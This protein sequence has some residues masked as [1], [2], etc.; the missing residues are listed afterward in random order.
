MEIQIAKNAGFCFGVKRALKIVAALTAEGGNIQ[1]Y[2]ELIHN[3]AVLRDLEKH[4]VRPVIDFSR[5]DRQGVLVIRSHGIEREI[6]DRLRVE[7]ISYV[8]ATCPFV[9][10]IHHLITDL[11]ARGKQIVLAG[12]SRHPEIIGIKSYFRNGGHIVNSTADLKRVPPAREMCILAQTTLDRGLYRRLV[13]SLLEKTDKLEV[14][15]TICAATETR[16]K[17]A[18]RLAAKVDAFVVVGG[19]NSSNTRKLF[20]IARRV[21]KRTYHLESSSDLPGIP[22]LDE[23]A[24]CSSVGIHGGASTPPAEIE[25]VA[26]YLKDFDPKRR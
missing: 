7:R 24:C 3:P 10:K 26:E 13:S 5:I 19:R 18:R 6:E 21:N 12:D 17:E 9:K 11:S 8:D 22:W 4:G 14:F 25:R 20:D 15:N 16:Q 23:L 1:T 2:G